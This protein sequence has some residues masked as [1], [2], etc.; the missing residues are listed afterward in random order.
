MTRVASARACRT[1]RGGALRSLA[2]MEILLWLVPAGVVTV[3]AMLWAG[4]QGRRGRAELDRAEGVRRLGRALERPA[5]SHD[6]APRRTPERS[7]AVVV[8]RSAEKR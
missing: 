3:L 6:P 8:R 2:G 4:W 7:R 5:P 1:R